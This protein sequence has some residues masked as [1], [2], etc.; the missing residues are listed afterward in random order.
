MEKRTCLVVAG[1]A[2]GAVVFGSLARTPLARLGVIERHFDAVLADER[3][4]RARSTIPLHPRTDGTGALGAGR[5]GLFDALQAFADTTQKSVYVDRRIS[6]TTT[7]SVRQR[8]RRLD[9]TELRVLLRDVDLEI[10]SELVDGKTA[11]RV[12]P[13]LRPTRRRGSLSPAR[14]GGGASETKDSRGTPGPSASDG[15]EL[16]ERDSASSPKISLYERRDGNGAAYVVQL[17]TDDAR[18]AQEALSLLRAL[19]RGEGR[20]SKSGSA[21]TVRPTR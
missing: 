6:P 20:E 21:S 2:A 12:E 10:S 15:I 1:L 17:V 7:V 8:I 3:A 9:L 4:D 19:R 16:S 14:G 13:P 11:Y 18:E 5:V